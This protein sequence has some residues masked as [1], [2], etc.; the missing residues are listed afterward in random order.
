MKK[1]V[2]SA[3]TVDTQNVKCQTYNTKRLT[4]LRY[5]LHVIMKIYTKTGDTGMTSLFGGKRVKK[6]DVQVEA[7]GSVDEFSSLLGLVMTKIVNKE[8]IIFWTAVQTDL[9]E[10]MALLSNAPMKKEITPRIE[11]F[12]KKI[13]E[14]WQ[15]LPPLHNFILPQ[16][17]ELSAWFHVLRTVCRRAEREVVAYSEENVK[18]EIQESLRYL[19]RLSDLLFAFARLYNREAEKKVK[20]KLI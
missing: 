7:Y 5:K 10:I 6:Y 14:I 18:K 11:I 3:I 16:G 19:N 8:E 13:D 12:E 1:A 4:F 20:T 9:Y 15:Q 17:T 2:E